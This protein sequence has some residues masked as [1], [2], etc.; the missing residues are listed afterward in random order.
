[1]TLF[2]LLVVVTIVGLYIYNLKKTNWFFALINVLILVA[3]LPII[4]GVFLLLIFTKIFS[5]AEEEDESSKA[6][7]NSSNSQ[8]NSSNTQGVIKPFYSDLKR[9]WEIE[10]NIP[11][12]VIAKAIGII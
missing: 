3:I 11:I 7:I 4:V 10:G 8:A 5:G 2:K 9:T 12:S 6:A 1:M